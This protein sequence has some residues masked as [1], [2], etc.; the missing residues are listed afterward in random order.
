MDTFRD[1]VNSFY[2]DVKGMCVRKSC[3]PTFEGEEILLHFLCN[4]KLLESA[5]SDGRWIL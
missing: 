1:L 3:L 4:A 2:D 5:D